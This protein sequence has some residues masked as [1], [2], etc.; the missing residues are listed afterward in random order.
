MLLLLLF[1]W[2]EYFDYS[3]IKVVSLGTE[4]GKASVSVKFS[5]HRE[6]KIKHKIFFIFYLFTLSSKC[7]N[8]VTIHFKTLGHTKDLHYLA[9]LHAYLNRSTLIFFHGAIIRL[10]LYPQT[11]W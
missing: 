6:N 11:F 8:V 4:K 9:Q 10:Q 3:C 5:Q 1:G 7:F 2:V